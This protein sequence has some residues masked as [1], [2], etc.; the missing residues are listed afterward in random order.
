[1]L[2]IIMFAFSSFFYILNKNTPKGGEEFYLI[3]HPD[4]EPEYSL[5]YNYVEEYVGN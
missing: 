3:L 1:M 5:S 4:Y 2:C